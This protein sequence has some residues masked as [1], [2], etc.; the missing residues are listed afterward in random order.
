MLG[1]SDFESES[2]L[3][4]KIAFKDSVFIGNSKS[5]TIRCF[6][7]SVYILCRT[8]NIRTRPN[9]GICCIP[10]GLSLLLFTLIPN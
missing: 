1:I 4:L 2:T 3:F 7:H 8:P 9:T 10:S 5:E 6:L